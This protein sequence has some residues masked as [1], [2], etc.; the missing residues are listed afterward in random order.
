MTW[1]EWNFTKKERLPSFLA[2]KHGHERPNLNTKNINTSSVF[3]QLQPSSYGGGLFWPHLSLS[4]FC[5]SLLSTFQHWVHT[6]E[7]TA[8]SHIQ[9]LSSLCSFTVLLFPCSITVSLLFVFLIYPPFS[10]SHACSLLQPC[11]VF[12][13]LWHLFFCNVLLSPLSHHPLGFVFARSLVQWMTM[14][15]LSNYSMDWL[16]TFVR[17]FV[18]PVGQ[19]LILTFPVSFAVTFLVQ[20]HKI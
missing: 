4:G 16:E 14:S 18:V 3:W 2:W 8:T 7:F 15:F 10:F 5:S 17:I 9:L 12:L 1:Q 6:L 19:L 13:F 20:Y 11:V